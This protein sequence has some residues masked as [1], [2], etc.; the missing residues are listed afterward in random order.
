LDTVKE[1]E[2]VKVDGK[3]QPRRNRGIQAHGSRGMFGAECYTVSGQALTI[4]FSLKPRLLP[5]SVVENSEA[6]ILK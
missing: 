5:A 3:L 2:T 1:S 4:R 6:E